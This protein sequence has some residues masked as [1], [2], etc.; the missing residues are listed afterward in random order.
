MRAAPLLLAA[1]LLAA[2]PLPAAA[3]WDEGNA[4]YLRKDWTTAV[5]ELKPLADAGHVGALARLGHMT[6]HGQGVAKDE[7]AALRL[8]LQAAEKGDALSQNTVGGMYFR[9]LGTP[10]DTVQAL[11]WFGRAADQNQPN[12]LNNLGQLYLFGNGVAQDEAKA[13]QLLRRAADAGIPAAA[14][15]MG[16]A[17]WDGKG[18]GLDHGE[19]VN[20]FRKAAER[21]LM[22]A[23]NRLGTALWNGDGI[24]KNPTEALRWFQLAADQGDGASLYNLSLAYIHGVGT[25]KD[26]EKAALYAILAANAAKPV[27]ISRFEDARDKLRTRTDAA[28]WSRAEATARDWAPRKLNGEAMPPEPEA[29]AAGT[30]TAPAVPARPKTNSGSGLIVGRDGT[31]LTNSHVVESCRNIRVT[32]ESQPA[33]AATVVARDAVND[34]AVLRASLRPAEVARFRE[35]KPMRSGDG[36]VAIGYP[37]S[38]YLSREPNVTVGVI[39]ALAGVRGDKRHYQITAPIQKGNSGGPVADLSGNVVGI[40]T[41]K[42]DAMKIADKTGDLPQNVNFAIKA[43]LARK[44]LADSGI[45]YDSAPADN[46]LSPADVG[47][48]VKKVTVFV[49][50]EG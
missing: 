23:Q 21:G 31:I 28:V 8:L 13:V 38:T 26:A 17:Y 19:A 42:L 6:L 30:P 27:D 18:V 7:A 29:Q 33:Q 22:L 1:V 20:W 47:D 40:V 43:E 34:L 15:A 14:E 16:I 39:S 11:I 36:V 10:R 37:L 45:P 32:L 4:A 50:C 12:A 9:G 5:R 3:G 2:S 41:A 24:A 25:A 44:F 49:E 35:D 48:I 46:Q